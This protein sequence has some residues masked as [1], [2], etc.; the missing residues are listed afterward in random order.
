MIVTKQRL[1]DE[2]QRHNIAAKQYRGTRA[3]APRTASGRTDRPDP[4]NSG[5]LGGATY[6][7]NDVGPEQPDR[8]LGPFG[9]WREIRVWRG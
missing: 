8:R 3:G 5:S 4:Q 9:Y 1:H 2:Y 7:C 6:L